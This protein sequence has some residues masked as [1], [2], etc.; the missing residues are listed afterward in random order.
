MAQTPNCSLKLATEER[1]IVA[2]CTY[3]D[4]EEAE[5]KDKIYYLRRIDVYDENAQG[6]GLGSITLYA[7]LD[8]ILKETNGDV[9]KCYLTCFP[10]NYSFYV[11]N[12]FSPS[13]TLL[14]N[15]GMNENDWYRLSLDEKKELLF[16][17][18]GEEAEMSRDEFFQDGDII[19]IPMQFHFKNQNAI[20]CVN[21][22]IDVIKATYEKDFQ[23]SGIEEM[24]IDD[25]E[26]Q[27]D[28]EKMQIDDD[29]PLEQQ[30]DQILQHI[31]S[32]HSDELDQSTNAFLLS[33]FSFL[34]PLDNGK[35]LFE[36]ELESYKASKK[37]S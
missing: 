1:E 24:Q 32:I 26:K 11:R 9:D 14:E 2:E 29:Q 37:S 18:H 16:Q 4:S 8:Q 23:A 31:L 7:M 33:R 10:V 34:K 28:D 25:E 20:M 35:K 27:I 13:K 30:Y 3:Y 21:A 15:Y 22:N 6:K 17:K 36:N 19:Q 5:G 12:G